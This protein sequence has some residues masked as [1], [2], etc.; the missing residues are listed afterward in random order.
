MDI[1]YAMESVIAEVQNAF[2]LFFQT[3]RSLGGLT[4]SV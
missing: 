4:V 1:G 3:I 2:R